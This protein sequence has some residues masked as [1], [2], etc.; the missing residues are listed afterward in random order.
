MNKFFSSLGFIFSVFVITL[1]ISNSASAATCINLNSNIA[2]G[3][4]DVHY[5][6]PDVTK[7][8]N[9]LVSKGLLTATP[10]G[11]FGN[12]TQLAVKLFQKNNGLEVTGFAGPLTR[13]KISNISCGTS[14]SAPVA[15]TQP[16][17]QSVPVT[18]AYTTNAVS[19]N[20]EQV[21]ACSF[22]DLLVMADVISLDKADIARSA[23]GCGE[24]VLEDTSDEE[25]ILEDT[26]EDLTVIEDISEEIVSDEEI[27]DDTSE[28]E[29]VLEDISSDEVVVED[30]T[31]TNDDTVVDDTPD[32]EMVVEDTSADESVAE[33]TTIINDDTVVDNTIDEVIADDEEPI[34]DTPTCSSFSYSS[35]GT[36]SNSSQSR[37]VNSSSP[38]GCTGGNPVLS[39]SCTMAPVTKSYS[40]T[41]NGIVDRQYKV[42]DLGKL[43]SV[44]SAS[45]TWT[46]N[47]TSCNGSVEVSADGSDWT[48]KKNMSDI[49]S[50]ASFSSGNLGKIRYIKFLREAV[51]PNCVSYTV[52]SLKV[53]GTYTEGDTVSVATTTILNYAS[54]SVGWETFLQLLKIWKWFE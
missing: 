27:I 13:N 21:D 16:V 31:I 29:T 28:Q 3:S 42:F 22:I 15:H 1:L 49:A 52:S 53:S 8:Q 5:S 2:I 45:V 33:D 19:D 11:F 24:L 32:Q 41:F 4:K 30:I 54:V 46:D 40:N 14:V 23:M 12:D 26:S 25:L 48:I 39:Q 36:C 43:V 20:S 47:Q 7:L 34:V 38:S 35:W 10:N 9:F 50:P 6:T 51:K 17:T 18:P 44:N 37:T